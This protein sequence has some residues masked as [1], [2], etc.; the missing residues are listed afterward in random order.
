MLLADEPNIREVIAFPLNQQGEDLMMGAPAPVAAGAAE[1]TFD[2]A[3]FAAE[4]GEGL[5]QTGR[6]FDQK[7]RKNLYSFG[8]VAIFPRGRKGTIL[9]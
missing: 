7:R 8:P 4:S 2:R 1:G 5:K 6:F 9:V 3:G